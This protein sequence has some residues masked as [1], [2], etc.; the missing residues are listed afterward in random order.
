MKIGG[1]I[2]WNAIPICE[3]FNIFCLMGRHHMK[4]GSQCDLTDQFS[5]LEQ[6]SN[7]TP[8]LRKTYRDYIILVQK[9]C[10]EDS[11]DMRCTGR[12]KIWK[13]DNL[14]ADI[15]E[16]KEM[17]A[18]ELHARRLNVK[19]V[20]TP[21]K[22]DNFIFPVAD[23]AVKISGEDQDLRTSTLIRHRDRGEEQ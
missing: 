1:Q 11:L 10:Q 3:S 16:L 13:G 7:I 19:E 12:E 14:V 9:S 22:G 21:M 15:E 18:S 8:F 6:L 20:L 4:G 2:P 23:G 17:D 5:R